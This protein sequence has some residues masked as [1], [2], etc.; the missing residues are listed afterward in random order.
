MQNPF[1]GGHAPGEVP[2]F[3]KEQGAQVILSGGMGTRAV[4]FFENLGIQA[5]TGAA[6]TVR[7]GV[8]MYLD[9]ALTGAAPCTDSIEHQGT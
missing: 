8:K 5:A 6:G 4:D 2:A 3:I 7:E 9:G 1:G